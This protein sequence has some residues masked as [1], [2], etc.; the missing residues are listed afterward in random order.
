[1]RSQP[2]KPQPP[3]APRVP[4]ARTLHG[5][6]DVDD[7][8]WMRDH[9]APEFAAYLTAERAYYDAQTAL[10]AGLTEELFADAVAR[11]PSTTDDSVAWPLRGYRYWYRTP[12][13]AENRQLLRV[14]H[15]VAAGDQEPTLLLD[16][17]VLG[18]ATGYV[19]VHAALPS[20]DDQL[21]GWLVDTSGA[22]VY[23]LRFTEIETGREL[24]DVVERTYPGGA[25]SSDSAYFFYLVPD[26]VWRPHQVWRHAIGT[27][28]TQDVLVYEES[29]QRFDL[30]LT[31][32]RSGELII[33]TAASR[34][35]TEVR[36]IPADEPLSAPVVVEPRR[37]GVEYRVDHARDP[38]GGRGGL[39][40]V[41]D[42]GY[43]EFT[44]MR[45]P[46][47]APGRA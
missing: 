14:R 17:N 16:E 21:L 4:S 8:A 7:Y 9:D 36:L 20:P 45:A 35:T 33:M 44:L 27:P 2:I 46:V 37:R 15:D 40:I 30:T 25:W 18:A 23:Q 22:E 43:S 26:Q 3:R 19:D 5:Q 1:M 6:T 38:A 12:E 39:L 10:L 31:A 47:S 11:T 42:D 13:R 29:D 34:D 41:T 28:A 24:A 32:S